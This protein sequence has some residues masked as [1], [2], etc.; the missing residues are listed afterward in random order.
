MSQNFEN[1]TSYLHKYRTVDVEVYSKRI[2]N[3]TLKYP[4]TLKPHAFECTGQRKTIA[5]WVEQRV[6]MKH[7]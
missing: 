2:I 5:Q 7:S 1:H 4:E 6:L 3:V